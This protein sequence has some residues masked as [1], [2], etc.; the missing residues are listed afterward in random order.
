VTVY[1]KDSEGKRIHEEEI[2]LATDNP[3]IHDKPP[4]KPGYVFEMEANH[5][6]IIKQQLNAW[7]TGSAEYEVTEIEL[8]PNE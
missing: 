1:L 8:A 4:L 6:R 7:K 3:Y 5:Y 2:F